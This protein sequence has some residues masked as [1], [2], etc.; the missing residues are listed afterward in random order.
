MSALLAGFFSVQNGPTGQNEK[1]LSKIVKEPDCLKRLWVTQ[2]PDSIYCLAQFFSVLLELYHL[3]RFIYI[4]NTNIKKD[5]KEKHYIL[6][7]RDF[8]YGIPLDQEKFSTQQ[9]IS[10]ARM[11][12]Y[13]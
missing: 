9:V 8:Q 5:R 6:E 12:Q 4:K 2:I 13:I 1:A 3:V 7:E 11:N 10:Y